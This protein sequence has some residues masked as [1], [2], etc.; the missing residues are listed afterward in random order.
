MKILLSAFEP[1]GGES[2]NP[3]QIIPK[4]PSED[5]WLGHVRLAILDL[6]ETGAQPMASR[7]GRSIFLSMK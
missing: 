3:T 1:F 4:G 5:V 2:V 7:N 6:T